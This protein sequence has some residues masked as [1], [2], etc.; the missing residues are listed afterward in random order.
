M[1]SPQDQDHRRATMG[2]EGMQKIATFGENQRDYAIQIAPLLNI[3]TGMLMPLT[4]LSLQM[5]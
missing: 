5:Q 2:E 1:R 3:P 4:S